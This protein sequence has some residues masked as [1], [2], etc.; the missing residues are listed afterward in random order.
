MCAILGGLNR[1]G[2]PFSPR[3]LREMANS[4]AHRGPD[5]EGIY[6]KSNLGFGHRRLAILDLSPAGHQ[7]MLTPDQSVALVYNGEIYNYQELRIELETLGCAFHSNCDTEVV[8]NAWRYW[9]ADCVNRFNGMFAFAIWSQKED[10]IFLVRDR[11]GIKPLYYAEFGHTFLFG[12][13]QKAIFAYP[14]AR[15]ELDYSAFY[16]YFTFQNLFTDRT[17]FKQVKLLPAGS[18][19]SLSVKGSEPPQIRNYW[20]YHFKED[21]SLSDPLECREELDRLLTQAVGRQLVAD[22]ELGSYLSGGMDSGTLTALAARQIPDLKT[23]TGGFDISSASGMELNF[24]ERQRAEAMSALYG[25]EHYEMVLKAGDMERCMNKVVFHVEEPRVGQCYPNYYISRLASRFVKV[26]LSGAGGDELFGGYP[27]RYYRTADSA[28]FEEYIDRYYLF[29]Q[30]LAPNKTLQ[31]LFSPIKGQSSDIWTRDI[32]RDV[33]L[34]HANELERPED[35]VNH[36]LYFE[37]KTFL[38]GLLLVEDKLSMAHGLET[39]VPFLDNDLV[40]FAMRLPVK[41]KLNNLQSVSRVNE[42]EPGGKKERYF[43]RTNDGK[44]ILREAMR[45]YI[46]DSIADAVKQGFSGPDASWFKGQSIDYVHK[47]LLNPKSKLYDVL[48]YQTAKSLIE[49]HTSGHENR[50]LLIWSLLYTQLWLEQHFN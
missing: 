34:N 28:N 42:N 36:S 31:K 8:L 14:D 41:F 23:F 25:T 20:D 32:F 5:G 11:Y 12:S 17:F 39:R 16:E 47:I 46:P 1:D 49:E 27:W 33:F 15:K 38:H 40:D 9:G 43:Q 37:A 48:D 18:I 35:Y 3:I 21:S 6:T 45:K 26:V 10:K 19:L 30:R 13:E 29:W 2:A 44:H 4:V 24:D 22:V 50:R 7:P